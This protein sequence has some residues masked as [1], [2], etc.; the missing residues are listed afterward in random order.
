LDDLPTLLSFFAR[1]EG[2]TSRTGVELL[3]S[4][5]N[6]VGGLL[7]CGGAFRWNPVEPVCRWPHARAPANLAADS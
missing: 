7:Q 4:F 3:Q 5:S 2:Q 6:A 1:G